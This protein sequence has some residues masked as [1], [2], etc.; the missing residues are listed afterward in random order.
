MVN[1]NDVL[2]KGMTHEE[3]KE[4][5]NRVIDRLNNQN[6]RTELGKGKWI[7]IEVKYLGIKKTQGIELTEKR[8][9]KKKKSDIP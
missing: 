3:C 8:V 6:L 5:T 2:I 4:D 9:A 7:K 1:T